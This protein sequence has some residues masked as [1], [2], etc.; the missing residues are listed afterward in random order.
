MIVKCIIEMK[1]KWLINRYYDIFSVTV[2]RIQK[3]KDHLIG[4]LLYLKRPLFFTHKKY[5]DDDEDCS[6]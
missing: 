2:N 4:S 3:Q 6:F 5:D 1:T